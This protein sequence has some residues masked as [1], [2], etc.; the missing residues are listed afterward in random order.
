VAPQIT[1]AQLRELV[2]IG[3]AELLAANFEDKW[4]IIALL[5]V[6]AILYVEDGL[7]KVQMCFT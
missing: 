6:E 2:A 7:K 4:F 5:K 1:H 3:E